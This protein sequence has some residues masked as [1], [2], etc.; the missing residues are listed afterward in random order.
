MSL[1]GDRADAWLS[2]RL[3]ARGWRYETLTRHL[4]MGTFAAQG[5]D[6]AAAT[7]HRAGRVSSSQ[8]RLTL[9]PGHT[10][11]PQPL[12]HLLHVFPLPTVRTVH[13]VAQQAGSLRKPGAGRQ[14]RAHPAFGGDSRARGRQ[15]PGNTCDQPFQA[16]CCRRMPPM[17]RCDLG[18]R[19]SEVE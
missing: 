6:D 8:Q 3:G 14:R 18:R 2:L 9:F 19:D 17:R 4:R 7:N 16:Y 5:E 12:H 13:H 11:K 15:C 1:R 10:T